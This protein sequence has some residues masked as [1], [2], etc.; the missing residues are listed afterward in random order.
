MV[1]A[2]PLGALSE[3][4]QK[5]EKLNSSSIERKV[6]AG[7]DGFVDKIMKAVKQKKVTQSEYFKTLSDF[8]S[9]IDSAKG[10]SGQIE[11]V[12]ERTKLGGNAPILANTLGKLGIRSICMG[13]LGYPEI[14]PVFSGMNEK[15]QVIS[16]LPPGESDAVEFDDG[17]MI[18]SELS[19][20]NQYDWKYIKNTVGLEKIKQSVSESS[21][22]AFVDW[23]NLPY[24]SD[25][26][27]GML[28]DVIK[29]SAR[30]D[31]FFLFDLCDPSKKSV[32]EI[33]EVLDIISCFSFCG[34]VTLGL[35]ENEALKIWA[36]INGVDANDPSSR[37]KIP[38]VR[39]VGD[40]IYK[41]MSIDCLLIHPI[42]RTIA[43]HQ[44]E[45]IEQM[46]RLVTNPKVQTGGG[47]NL[48]AGYC[49]GLFAG[50]SLKECMLLGMATSGAYIQNGASP[51][52]RSIIDYIALWMREP[53][54][55]PKGTQQ[56]PETV[57]RRE[58]I[59]THRHE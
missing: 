46:G 41:A 51:D 20:F 49:L 57:Q 39:E 22:L 54:T 58:H 16:T 12:T 59:F 52:L 23:V 38:P 3:L 37:E 19:V 30:K 34:K 11:L 42:D 6:F 45:I 32:Q 33:D 53:T 47:D 29:P 1:T 55:E 13:S 10:R 44:H 5:L 40:A 48:N 8:A 2:T 31:F 14:H 43:F 15:C 18:F 27:L 9:R 4:K 24:A 17:K 21:L 50:L 28:E 25:I 36:A 26:W 56:K 35:N 7:F